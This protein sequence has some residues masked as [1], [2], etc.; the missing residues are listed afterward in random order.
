V[1]SPI[2]QTVQSEISN[3]GIL[4]FTA[5]AF[6]GVIVAIVSVL[7]VTRSADAAN[8]FDLKISGYFN[9]TPAA[10]CTGPAARPEVA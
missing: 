1:K 10:C 7:S 2:S 9:L 3:L 6:I 8:G 5:R 4:R